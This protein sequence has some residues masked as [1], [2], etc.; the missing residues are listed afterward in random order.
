MK[1]KKLWVLGLISVLCVLIFIF[2]NIL[3]N[4][5]WYAFPRRALKIWGMAVAALSIAL[6]TLIFQTL[7]QNRLLT[8]GILGLD[9]LY[10]LIQTTLVFVVGAESVWISQK[11]LNFI[12]TAVLLVLFTMFVLRGFMSTPKNGMIFLSL[13]GLIMGTLFQS[14]A[15]FLQTI[16]DPNEFGSIQGKM[17][18][19]FNNMRIELLSLTTIMV[20]VLGIYLY[21][22]KH[23]LDV[24]S[25][26]RTYAVNLGIEEA[27][28]RKRWVLIVGMLIAVSTALIGPITFLGLLGINL[29]RQIFKTYRHGI[30]MIGSILIVLIMLVSSQ[31]ITE[32]ILNFAIPV[33]VLIN[34]VG[35]LYFIVLLLKEKI[36]D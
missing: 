33:A 11:E 15:T 3:P 7:S 17:Y 16:I 24:M 32:H 10:I 30:L 29:T 20:V 22:Q 14:A 18:A 8:P 4:T 36:N 31:W 12:V 6:S 5:F 25:L 34:G 1:N 26:G 21:R 35:G 28:L 13:A 9:A 19:S 27:K 2:W 23:V